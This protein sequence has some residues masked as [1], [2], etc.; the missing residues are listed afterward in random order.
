V[1]ILVDTVQVVKEVSQFD[2]AVWVDDE[3]IVHVA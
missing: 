1:N 2:G 3:C